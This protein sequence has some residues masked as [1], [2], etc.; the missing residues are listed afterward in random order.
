[1]AVMVV[2]SAG[3]VPRTTP[4]PAPAFCPLVLAMIQE[5]HDDPGHF[6]TGEETNT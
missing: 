1:M 2:F 4:S 5:Q 6:V 3:R